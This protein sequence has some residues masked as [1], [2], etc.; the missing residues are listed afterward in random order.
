MRVL[1]GN[2]LFFCANVHDLLVSIFVFAMLGFL[3]QTKFIVCW[4]KQCLFMC[5]NKVDCETL[6]LASGSSGIIDK[7]HGTKT[8]KFSSDPSP[9][10]STKNILT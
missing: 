7:F 10:P 3:D 6:S 4:G 8:K 1:N 9:H 5:E 2:L